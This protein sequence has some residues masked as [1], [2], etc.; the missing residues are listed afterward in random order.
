M[1]RINS[2]SKHWWYQLV[3]GNSY[4][5]R[6]NNSYVW[7]CINKELTLIVR[8]YTPLFLEVNCS[9]M[10]ETNGNGLVWAP[11]T[12][13]NYD[14][15]VPQEKCWK[16]KNPSA[17]IHLLIQIVEHFLIQVAELWEKC[18]SDAESHWTNQCQRHRTNIQLWPERKNW[19]FTKLIQINIIETGS[20]E[21][22]N[23]EVWKKGFLLEPRYKGMCTFSTQKN[24]THTHAIW[25]TCL[26]GFV[27]V[28]YSIRTT[29]RE[30]RL[31][32]IH[33]HAI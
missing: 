20:K 15:K 22:K 10:N 1:S 29:I 28:L 16:R 5:W 13:K 11:S 30:S 27:F 18:Q 31:I 26:L 24:E 14:K 6:L 19:Q 25:D 7:V 9:C 3:Y 12:K 23:L 32:R 8:I 2:Y 33:F 21:Q 17:K 4:S